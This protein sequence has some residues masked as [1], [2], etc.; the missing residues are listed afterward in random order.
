MTRG[1]DLHTHSIRSDGTTSPAQNAAL[2]SEAGL[3][4]FALTDHDTLDGWD[5]AAAACARLNLDF[6]PGVEL[7]TELDGRSVHLLGYWVDPDDAALVAEC[8]RLRNERRRRAEA[9]VRRLA[10]LGLD[11]DMA[12]VE[13]RAAGAP[14]GRPHVAAAMVAAGHVPDM[15]TAFVDYIADGGPAYVPKYALPPEAGVAL[16]VQA[17]GAAVLAHPGLCS[18]EAPVDVPLLERL[19]D[20][21][22]SGVEADHCGHDEAARAF[23]RAA[24][25]ERDL[26]V[27]GASDFHGMR[28]DSRIGDSV[29]T[30]V[31]LEE[32]HARA[33]RA[34]VKEAARW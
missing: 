25:A 20:A 14:I 12:D 18:R 3:A 5:E 16:I 33:G 11:V 30:G 2:A 31:A 13:A 32:L 17:G 22:L 15:D 6:V 26:V 34:R 7:S 28:K 8:D 29:T 10:S 9:M 4:G 24:A 23:W 21:G 19:T 27:T 1:F